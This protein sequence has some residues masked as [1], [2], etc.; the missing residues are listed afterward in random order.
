MPRRLQL[1]AAVL[2]PGLDV[3]Q[4]PLRTRWAYSWTMYRLAEEVARRK[5]FR[6]FY[7]Y[8]SCIA[9]QPRARTLRWCR[10]GMVKLPGGQTIWSWEAVRA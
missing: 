2:S 9:P 10:R 1:P 3:G 7:L 4:G 5:F 6:A 8:F